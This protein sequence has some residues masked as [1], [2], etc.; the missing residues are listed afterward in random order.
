MGK[1]GPGGGIVFYVAPEPF[2]STGS[3]CGA[4]C[5]YL[6]IS[7]TLHF[8]DPWCSNTTEHLGVT[9]AGIGWGMYNTM[10][11]RKTCTSGA[12]KVAADYTNNGKTDWFLPSRD[13]L[14]ELCKYARTQTTGTTS[15][16]C[17]NFSNNRLFSPKY[18]WSS[19]EISQGVCL[20][21]DNPNY[22]LWVWAW[23]VDNP[24]L[25]CVGKSSSVGMVEVRAF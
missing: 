16:N 22:I 1:T 17:A 8:S 11:A 5:R 14:N 24:R 18:Y 9:A 7:P 3:D 25:L 20:N 23:S 2:A 13:E 6:E 15:T 4:A 10:W 19:T 12:I 21:T